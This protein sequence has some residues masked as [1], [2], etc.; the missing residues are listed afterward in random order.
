MDNDLAN[1]MPTLYSELKNLDLDN[2]TPLEALKKIAK[3]KKR[4]SN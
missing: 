1:N 3:W 4:L 2:L